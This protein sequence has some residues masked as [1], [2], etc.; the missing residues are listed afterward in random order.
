VGTRLGQALE[1][2]NRLGVVGGELGLLLLLELDT[3][4]L[5]GSVGLA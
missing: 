5:E 4:L 2:R 1:V 3:A